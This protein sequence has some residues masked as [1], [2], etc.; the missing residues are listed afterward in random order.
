MK[1]M[2]C[3]NNF[4]KWI[5]NH[6]TKKKRKYHY[7][8]DMN[9]FKDYIKNREMNKYLKEENSTIEELIN[10]HHKKRLK[11]ISE[12]IKERTS[13]LK[14]TNPSRFISKE[15]S[16]KEKEISK[17]EKLKEIDKD[18]Q[19]RVSDLD[20]RSIPEKLYDYGVKETYKKNKKNKKRKL[21]SITD[22]K[23]TIK[24]FYKY[25]SEYHDIKKN[26]DF[27][28]DL[29]FKTDRSSLTLTEYKTVIDYV[30]SWDLPDI[31]PTEVHL[32]KM[33]K[34]FI[35]TISN[36]GMTISEAKNLK[37]NQVTLGF[38]NKNETLV[39]FKIRKGVQGRC[40]GVFRRLYDSKNIKPDDYVFHQG[41]GDKRISDTQYYRLWNLIISNTNLYN[42]T[43][44]SLRY[45][46]LNLRY[47]SGD[48]PSFL[49]ENMGISMRYFNEIFRNNKRR[50]TPL[51]K[52]QKEVLLQE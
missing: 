40:A 22:E 17:K 30:K 42:K 8:K 12:E 31:E 32:R 25:L 15:S 44:Q 39:N 52:E 5:E 37:W 13:Q 50:F 9:R 47:K 19:K 10:K 48:N 7:F 24:L 27:G 46:F 51:T 16:K 45:T 2:S 18:I 34:D 6:D 21:S 41:R 23:R 36:T 14:T 28:D 38:T 1:F 29:K 26:V 3:I 11:K 20:I 33:V 43:Y 4:R 35:L 49:C